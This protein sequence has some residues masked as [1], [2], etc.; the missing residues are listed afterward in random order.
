MFWNNLATFSLPKAVIA[1]VYV[2]CEVFHILDLLYYNTVAWNIA[3]LF[4]NIKAEKK[5]EPSYQIEQRMAMFATH[6]PLTIKNILPKE[7]HQMKIDLSLQLWKWNG[8][9]YII[10]FLFI[11]DQYPNQEWKNIFFV[12]QQCC[13]THQYFFRLLEA[14]R[15]FYIHFTRNW[16][17]LTKKI[18]TMFF[19]WNYY[20]IPG[21]WDGNILFVK[22]VYRCIV[23]YTTY[24][25]PI[26]DALPPFCKKNFRSFFYFHYGWS[27]L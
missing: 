18:R 20:K 11:V 1:I 15:R 19:M 7:P 13:L 21:L 2:L 25:L 8:E 6:N 17:F 10:Q 26:K 27:Y 12:I 22:N 9:V 16:I 24:H 23:G 5:K 3:W 4:E 14:K